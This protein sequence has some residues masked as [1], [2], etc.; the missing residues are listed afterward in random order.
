MT[1]PGR[2]DP[3]P[4]GSG[5]KYKHCCLKGGQSSTPILGGPSPSLPTANQ[6]P[7]APLENTLYKIYEKEAD[8]FHWFE[9]LDAESLRRLLLY[10]W[11][12]MLWNPVNFESSLQKFYGHVI[13]G[14]NVVRFVQLLKRRHAYCETYAWA[15]PNQEAIDTLVEHSPLIEAGAGRGYWAAL[16][17][18]QGAD[19]I[20]F[21]PIPPDRDGA[22]SWHRQPGMF[23]NVIRADLD[24]I[25]RHPERTLVLC[26]PPFNS[27]VALRALR[28]Y[29]GQTVIYVGDEG[30]DA[31][32]PQFY[33][34]LAT[35]FTRIQVVDIPRW[36]GIDD[37]L[38]VWRR[39]ETAFRTT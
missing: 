29:K 18:A 37:R 4:C 7:A 34:E 11:Y 24:I 6:R 38:E 26:W 2:N 20:A 36:P 13:D 12:T 39:R 15:I 9:S 1:N 8:L 5:K 10:T 32:T 31:G 14:P 22:N 19:I 33:A 28:T 21:D 25:S 27:D 3:C 16:A 23:F 17:A 35:Y 30:R